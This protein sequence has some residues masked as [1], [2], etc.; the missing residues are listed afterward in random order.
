[1]TRLVV[2]V[3]MLVACGGDDSGAADGGVTDAAA[4][5]DA[6][7]PDAKPNYCTLLEPAYGDLGSFTGTALLRPADAEEPNGFEY[8]SIE[9]P[10]NTDAKPDVLFI[11]LWEDAPPFDPDFKTGTFTLIEDNADIIT[12]GVCAFIAADREVGQNLR[13]H[14]AVAGTMTIDAVDKTPGTGSV[15]GSVSGLRLREITVDQFGQH[16]VD[17]GCETMV[18]SASFTATVQAPQ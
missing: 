6:A 8:L 4:I 12:C 11:E 3:L 1:M 10:L 18:D 2:A 15:V 5:A 9:I 14:M 17:M 7:T 16:L 13:F